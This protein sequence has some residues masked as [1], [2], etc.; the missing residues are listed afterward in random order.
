M[1]H[2]FAIEKILLHFD[3]D[4]CRFVYMKKK[5][6]SLFLG[7]SVAT[8]AQQDADLQVAPATQQEPVVTEQAT[9]EAAPT[10]DNLVVPAPVEN[11]APVE[12]PA[13]VE[14]APAEIPPAETD[15]A[16]VQAPVNSEPVM[17]QAGEEGVWTSADMVGSTASAADTQQPPAPVATEAVVTVQEFQ[18]EPA[19]V[20]YDAVYTP[21]DTGLVHQDTVKLTPFNEILH[22]NSYNPVAN[23]AAAPTVAGELMMPH[24]MHNR[25]FAYFEPIDQEG[26]VSFGTGIT[27]FFAFDNTNSLGLVTAGMAF[28]RLG[29]L[30][31]AA[32]G[33]RWKYV[34]DD[35]SGT[36]ETTKGT[37]AGTVIG[38]TLSAMLGGLDVAI[39]VAYD[40]PENESTVKGGN[41]ESESDIWNLGGRFIVS[42]T[43]G[44]VSWSAGA[45]VFRHNSKNKVTEKSVFEKN[46]R[47]YMSTS[48]IRTTDSTARIEVVPEFNLGGIIL[49][50]E[51]ARVYMGVNTAIPL[52]VYD[53]IQGV[54]SRHNEYAFT[55]TPNILGEVMLG[56]YLL[57]YGSASHQWDLFRYRDS[58]I[59]NVSTKT[60][61]ISS[62][63]TTANIGLRLTYEMAAVE[64]TL[65][66][67]FLGNPFGAF[68]TTE[69]MATSIGMF[70]NF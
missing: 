9:A 29:F 19:A 46:G 26:V 3:V 41:V 36:E 7:V 68:S 25:N 10:L 2:P 70:I 52:I 60:M 15:S 35:N 18:T 28:D 34:D 58:Y 32:V 39:R 43:G 38:G 69:A 37:S 33:K 31:Q 67:Q 64:M 17:G 5:L 23:E 57:A 65:T 53:R 54:C 42:Y 45:G 22:G 56:K 48:I 66:K 51:K 47:Q 63:I 6:V 44:I 21:A 13:P 24:H 55:A 1:G 40:H 20:S 49:N 50:R 16:L 14:V 27:Y 11:T 12:T 30:L 61:D 59:D 4:V 8:W 62:G